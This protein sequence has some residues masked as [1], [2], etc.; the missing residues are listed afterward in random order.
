MNRILIFCCVLSIIA[1]QSSP[2]FEK[3]TNPNPTS[4]SSVTV[5]T[6]SIL[7]SL[8]AGSYYPFNDLEATLLMI[9]KLDE[10]KQKSTYEQISGKY[11]DFV[12]M[13]F[14]EVVK[15]TDGTLLEIYRFKGTFT[16]GA[17]KEI[18]SVLDGNDKLAGFFIKPWSEELR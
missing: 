2:K 14:H 4:V 11:G 12:A 1:C 13:T 16:N 3:I 5:L 18:R 8:K 9:E 10:Q 15:P 6:N 17:V 7:D